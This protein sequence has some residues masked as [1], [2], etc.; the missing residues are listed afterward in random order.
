M[1]GATCSHQLA[2]EIVERATQSGTQDPRCHS[3]RKPKRHHHP[4]FGRLSAPPC[5]PFGRRLVMK[6]RAT[7]LVAVLAALALLL[8]AEPSSAAPTVPNGD[9]F[10]IDLPGDLPAVCDFRVRITVTTAQLQ[11]AELPNGLQVWSGAAVAT[12][13]NLDTTESV[14]YN[15]S[16]PSKPNPATGQVTLYGQNLLLGLEGLSGPGGRK[17]LWLTNGTVSLTS[18]QPV[19]EEDLRGHIR[20]DVCAELTS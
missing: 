11:R 4:V 5:V 15:I 18:L 14:T 7:G 3:A 1:P 12:V 16:G 6:T 2:N 20:F 9:K 10:S 13:T 19:F 8:L 17:F